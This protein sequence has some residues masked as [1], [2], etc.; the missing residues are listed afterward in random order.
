[1]PR[2]SII[3]PCWNHGR[4]LDEALGSA[5]A[6]TRDDFEILVVDDG[7]TDPETRALLDGLERPK[8]RVLRAEHRGVVAARNL[9]LA[10][11]TGDYLCFFDADDRMDPRFLERTAA[12]LDGDAGLAF[13]SCWVRLF[14]DEQWEWRPESCELPALLGECTVATAALVRREAVRAVS[15][16]DPAMEL[17]HEDWDLW[18]S[19]VAGGGRGAIVPEVLFHY[20]RSGASRS[21][22]ADRGATYLELFGDLLR[23][24]AAAYR[25]HAFD[26]LWAKDRAIAVELEQIVDGRRHLA[27][28]LEPDVAARE[29]AVAAA[30]RALVDA[31]GGR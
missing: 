14:G 15:G 1:L 19:I 8:T 23:K 31:K 12:R 27:E 5:L 22:V 30:W 2:I 21:T 9:G 18:L 16:F 20:R 25:A 7:S 6:Q 26:V 28:A 17:G 29:R 24:H 13:A 11:A 3:T 4:F 10:E